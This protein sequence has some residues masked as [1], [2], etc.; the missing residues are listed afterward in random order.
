MGAALCLRGWTHSDTASGA[1]VADAVPRLLVQVKT[2]DPCTHAYSFWEGVPMDGKAGFGRLFAASRTL[3]AVAVVQRAMRGATS[4]AEVMAGLGFGKLALVESFSVSMSGSG[5]SFTCYVFNRA[6][7]PTPLALP[8][9]PALLPAADSVDTPSQRH[10][11]GGAGLSQGGLGP[12]VGAEAELEDEAVSA[13]P[14]LPP[15]E[16][17]PPRGEG[18]SAVRRSTRQRRPTAKV[19]EGAEEPEQQGVALEPQAG[20]RQ[21]N[22]SRAQRSTHRTAAAAA[23]VVRAAGG[24]QR[25]SPSKGNGVQKASPSKAA[26]SPSKAKAQ[27]LLGAAGAALRQK[28]LA[29]LGAATA[30]AKPAKQAAAGGAE[31]TA[32]RGLL[33]A[34]GA[35]TRS[36]QSALSPG[37]QRAA[38][39]AAHI[40][41]AQ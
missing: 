34:V 3:R 30:G 1:P 22:C 41:K 15:A 37:S 29:P 10:E 7:H 13:P 25:A 36:M 11:G 14:P 39:A 23:T 9:L 2:L 32:R 6:A 4:P 16:L 33:Q 20:S 35:V 5:R 8:R 40:I 26:S 18:S 12:A 27:G 24:K 17:L 28:K 38:A 31:P 19:V 21:P